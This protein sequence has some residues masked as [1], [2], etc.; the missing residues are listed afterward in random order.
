MEIAGGT[1]RR[2]KFAGH[3]SAPLSL[4]ERIA[5]AGIRGVLLVRD[6]TRAAAGAGPRI[7]EASVSNVYRS[8]L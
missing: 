2:G 6:R 3:R 5:Q 4:S 1:L 8:I 7:A